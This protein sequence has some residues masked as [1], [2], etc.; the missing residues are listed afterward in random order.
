MQYVESPSGLTRTR[1]SMS[2]RALGLVHAVLA[3]LVYPKTAEDYLREVFPL[4]SRSEVLAEVVAVRRET[5]DTTTLVLRPNG[6]F[7]GH[8][9]GQWITLEAEIAGVRRTRCFSI[10]SAP[11]HLRDRGPGR[12]HRGTLEITVKARPGGVVTPALVWGQG[13][14]AIVT[15]SQAQGTFVL[16]EALPSRP[17]FVSGGSGITPVMSMLRELSLRNRARGATFVH[18]A[19]TKADVVFARELEEHG[20]FS[21]VEL[22]VF[23]DDASEGR[24]DVRRDLVR[25]VPDFAERE[26]FACG[27]GGLLASMSTLYAERGASERLHT[28]A[29]ALTAAPI[30]FVSD[31]GTEPEPQVHFARAEKTQRGARTLL[32]MAESAGLTP[33]SGCRMGICHTCTCRKVSGVTRD[34]RTGEISTDANVDVCICVTEPVGNVILDL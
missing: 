33:K 34:V 29:F 19:R 13:P 23:T 21:G 27:P 8:R 9:A 28:E 4:I 24:G 2:A 16:P 14:G 25:D 6:L 15:L 30:A 22:H 17:L 20:L 32:A 18:Y 7:R 12:H 26:T 5:A 1:P 3:P 31:A 11:S 10:S